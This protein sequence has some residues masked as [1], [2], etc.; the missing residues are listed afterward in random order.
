MFNYENIGGKM[1]NFYK[2]GKVK[3]NGN[4]VVVESNMVGEPFT[5][6]YA[7]NQS[8]NG[9][10]ATDDVG[11]HIHDLF[12]FAVV[13]ELAVTEFGSSFHKGSFLA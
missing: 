3:K 1:A 9:K 2:N 4:K 10:A 11:D 5:F 8:Q 12:A 7:Q 6:E 13:G